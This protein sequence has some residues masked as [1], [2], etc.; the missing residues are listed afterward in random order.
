VRLDTNQDDYY[1]GVLAIATWPVDLS[2]ANVA[3]S[4]KLTD[5]N[6]GVLVPGDVTYT[7]HRQQRRPRRCAR[8]TGVRPHPAA[9]SGLHLVMSGERGLSLSN[10]AAAKCSWS[11]AHRAT[12]RDRHWSWPL[13]A[14]QRWS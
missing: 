14:V 2:P 1:L 9:A 10:L 6:G 3:L 4:K 11:L 7:I 13:L 8:H 5:V 12:R